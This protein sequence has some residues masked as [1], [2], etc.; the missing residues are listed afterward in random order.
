MYSIDF[1][2]LIDQNLPSVLNASPL[3]EMIQSY[4][5]PMRKEHEAFLSFKAD[6]DI[7]ISHDGRVFSMRKRLNDKF[8]NS[9]RRIT[10]IDEVIPDDNRIGNRQS[11]DQTYVASG[12]SLPDQF[13]I[14]NPPTYFGDYDFVVSVPDSLQDQDALI[15][16][17]INI[18]KFA[19]KT[20]KINYLSV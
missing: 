1:D 11:L 14:G 19:G 20:F 9:A 18:Y 12:E 6:I 4:Q 16:N 15:R 13:Y 8:D 17:E 5:E 7:R 10:I 2:K 3:K